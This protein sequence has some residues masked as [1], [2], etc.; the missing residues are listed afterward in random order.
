M[1]AITGSNGKT[2]TKEILATL[3]A[4]RFRTAKS[5]GNLNNLFGFP[6]ALLGIDES[7]EWLVAE[8]GM[9][10]PG[11]L[12]RLSRLAR[13]DVAVVTSVRPVHLEFFGTLTAIADAK[14]E[15]L[16]G[17]D[18]ASPES[19]FVVNL[20]DP[21]VVRIGRRW[22]GRSLTFGVGR[23]DVHATAISDRGTAGID[24][25]GPAVVLVGP[26][27]GESLSAQEIEAALAYVRAHPEIWEVILTGGDPFVLSARRIEEITRALGNIPHIKILR[28]HTRVPAVDP[29]RVTPDR[30]LYRSRCNPHPPM[31]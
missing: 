17:M 8:M 12:G 3:L 13:P 6:L 16:E 7:A 9:S 21:E 27:L 10:T 23:G 1:V 4:E 2:T 11:E 22:A 24:P 26:Q 25:A 28:W 20:D 14:A 15:I 18:P 31:S 30:V 19:T 29:L 5:P